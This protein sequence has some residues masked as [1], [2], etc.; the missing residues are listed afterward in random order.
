MFGEHQKN[1]APSLVCVGGPSGSPR[2]QIAPGV[3]S[4]WSSHDPLDHLFCVAPVID[5][6]SYQG[7]GVASLQPG[8]VLSPI[9]TLHPKHAC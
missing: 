8:S 3:G 5:G 6:P 9:C 7:E 2:A 4:T 1:P